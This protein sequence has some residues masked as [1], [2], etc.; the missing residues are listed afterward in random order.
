[1]IFSHKFFF[2]FPFPE[3]FLMI[4]EEAWAGG[5]AASPPSPTGTVLEVWG[6]QAWVQQG[7]PSP[8]L[9]LVLHMPQGL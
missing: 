8:L 2:F 3:I 6:H 9:P 4:S 7:S 5:V 1:M